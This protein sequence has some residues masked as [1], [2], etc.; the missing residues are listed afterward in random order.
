MS[1]AD[2]DERDMLIDILDLLEHEPSEEVALVA[3]RL[4]GRYLE[5]IGDLSEIE[6]ANLTAAANEDARGYAW[7][8]ASAHAGM[9]SLWLRVRERVP[10][11]T[12][13]F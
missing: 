13:D 11:S 3:A 2:A 10:D 7:T 1:D 9:R 6:T 8:C 5:N 12:P 4:A